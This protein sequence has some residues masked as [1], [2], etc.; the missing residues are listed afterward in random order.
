MGIP[1]GFLEGIVRQS[2]KEFGGDCHDQSADWSRNDTS[3]LVR[4]A[5]VRNDRSISDLQRLFY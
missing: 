1:K 3:I 2:P 5:L 4:C